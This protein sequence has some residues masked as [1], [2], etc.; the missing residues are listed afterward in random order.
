LLSLCIESLHICRDLLFRSCHCYRLQ[1]RM[2]WNE[3]LMCPSRGNG[4]FEW[5]RNTLLWCLA[6]GVSKLVL[7]IIILCLLYFVQSKL[8]SFEGCNRLATGKIPRVC[9]I[10]SSIIQ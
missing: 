5:W 10:F 1:M 4:D 8:V 2:I 7:Q 9:V 6:T 3:C